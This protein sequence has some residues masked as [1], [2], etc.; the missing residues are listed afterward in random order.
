MA[1]PQFGVSFGI[2]AYP[3]MHQNKINIHHIHQS[4]DTDLKSDS[5][6]KRRE[7]CGF[8]CLLFKKCLVMLLQLSLSSKESSHRH[9]NIT[10]VPFAHLRRQSLSLL[11]RASQFLDG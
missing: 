5:P 9:C 1:E 4:G 10:S 8:Y 2:S 11:K 6:W 7:L 3:C